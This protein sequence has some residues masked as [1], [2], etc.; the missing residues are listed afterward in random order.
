MVLFK[1]RDLVFAGQFVQLVLTT[2][3][4][5]TLEWRARACGHGNKLM[6]FR[7]RRGNEEQQSGAAAWWLIASP[8]ARHRSL[9]LISH[10]PPWCQGHHNTNKLLALHLPNS[11][12][13]RGQTN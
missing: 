3:S 12:A 11:Y 6:V 4:Q 7:E 9:P 5:K 13:K 1:D 8:E 2:L 10:T